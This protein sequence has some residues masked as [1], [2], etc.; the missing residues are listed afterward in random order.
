MMEFSQNVICFYYT[1]QAGSVLY[2]PIWQLFFNKSSGLKISI[3]FKL[4]K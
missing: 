3:I 4:D 2:T 1:H